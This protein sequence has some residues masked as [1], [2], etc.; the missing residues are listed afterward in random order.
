VSTTEYTGF[1][2]LGRVT[3]HK[4][5]TDGQ[6]YTTGYV[7]NLSGALIEQTYPSGRVVK[8]VLDNNGDL[9][10]VQS[11]KNS[12]YGFFTYANSFTY[13][14]AGAVT[15][16]Q[17]GNG[18][19]ESTQ[20]NSRLQPTQIALGV[21]QG[22]TNLLDLDY[23]YGTTA[24]NGNLL[25]QT[26]TVPTVG[27]NTGFSAVQTYNYDS[28]NRLKDA[29][30]MLTPT[31]GSAT[32]SWKQTFVFDRYGNRNFDEANTA[33][34]GFDKLCNNNTELCADLR[35]RLNPSI[36]TSN[37][38]LSTSDD[39]DFDASGNTTSDPDD[40]MF[41]YDAENKQVEVKDSLNATIGQYFYDGDGRR[42]KKVVPGGETTIFVYDAGSKLIGEYSTVVQTGSNAKTVY[43]TNDHLGS[44]RINTDGTGQVI[45]RH[46]YHPF[47]EEIA[48][49]GYGSDTIRKHLTGYER[50]GETGLDFAQ[51]R[52][53]A[54]VH[55]R[56]TTAD[57][58]IIQFEM[59]RGDD[60]EERSEML[61]EY[62][63]EP[64]NHNRYVYALNNPVRH[65][66]PSGMRPPNYW[67]QMALNKLDEWIAGATK[68]G[69][70]DLA[71]A[72][73]NAKAE[74]GAIIDKLGKK[75]NSVA[76]GIAVY[77]ILSVGTDEGNKYADS[78][79]LAAPG[80][81]YGAGENKCNVFV[82]MAHIN[83]GGIRPGNYPSFG[84]K[85]PVA[86][87]LGDIRD[88]MK[89]KNLP[90]HYGAA[91]VGDAVAWRN[92]DPNQPGHSGVSIGGGAMI[93]AGGSGGGRPKVDTINN[94]NRH[95][96]TEGT[97]VLGITIIGPR[98]E[99][100]VIRRF[101]GKP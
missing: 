69:N 34:A 37:N 25:S 16:M 14:P 19:W 38:R 86:N 89:L 8:N 90:V 44:P 77:A 81:T 47:G 95:M 93:Y 24:N 61:L 74:I 17:L 92:T 82:A 80:H 53:Q 91:G 49:T 55:G 76:V 27:T 35:K 75:Q 46:D 54:S 41:I 22:A 21:T 63:S 58:Y 100:G 78:T 39:Y 33:F 45:S 101:N 94:M 85:F 60:A 48:R 65:T 6:S 11:K 96:N 52:Y 23:S 10:L 59:K 67:E 26:I 50:D 88:S 42:V 56:F 68:A 18:R 12:A 29:T 51:A 5:T 20:F 1:D 79:V 98:H 71:T 99:P 97:R 40:R 66:D 73:T 7:Y 32:Q 87:W 84:G 62:L 28:L 70:K 15:S 13:N 4:Q 64:R 2:I 9:S 36:N 3:A 31:G 43:T 30:E 57:P 83:G 72:L